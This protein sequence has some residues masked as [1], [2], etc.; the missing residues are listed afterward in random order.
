MHLVYATADQ[1]SHVIV[2]ARNSRSGSIIVSSVLHVDRL[3]LSTTSTDRNY[4]DYSV[5]DDVI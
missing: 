1:R 5:L 2:V 3:R 4:T